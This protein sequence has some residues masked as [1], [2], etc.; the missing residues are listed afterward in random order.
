L[1]TYVYNLPFLSAANTRVT[2]IIKMKEEYVID[3]RHKCTHYVCLHGLVVLIYWKYF[4]INI[5]Y[6]SLGGPT[7]SYIF[8]IIDNNFFLL[9]L[10]IYLQSII[11]LMIL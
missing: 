1:K 9:C 6:L 7:Y 2:L 10:V 3:V 8:N 5:P 4:E 11:L